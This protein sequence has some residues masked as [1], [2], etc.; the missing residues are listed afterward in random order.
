MPLNIILVYMLNGKLCGELTFNYSL[1]MLGEM[2]RSIL[3]VNL[4]KQDLNMKLLV[5][6]FNDF[7]L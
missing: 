7:K 2:K 6:F 5:K 1:K 3:N 4:K